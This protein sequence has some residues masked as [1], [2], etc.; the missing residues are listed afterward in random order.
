LK[1]YLIGSLKNPKIPFF[2]NRLRE[3]GFDTF[4]EWFGAGKQAD[5]TWRLYETARGRSYEE[6]LYSYA[7]TNIFQ[8]DL[9]HMKEADIAVLMLPAGRSGHLEFGY[10][11]GQGKLGYVL[12]DGLPARWD[13]MFQFATKVY[14]HQDALL[15]ELSRVI[16]R[17]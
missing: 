5:T 3:L 7:A 6:A 16:N 15:R 8:F 13:V 9:R 1:I 11:V 10:M 14:F 2:G 4:D 12:F 17:A